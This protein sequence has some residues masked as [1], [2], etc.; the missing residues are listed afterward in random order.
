MVPFTGFTRG[1]TALKVNK[2]RAKW[3]G[4]SF[5]WIDMFVGI[6]GSCCR[7]FHLSIF[8]ALQHGCCYVVH[9]CEAKHFVNLH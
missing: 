3:R 8:Q 5:S 7:Q 1:L 2:N 6:L 4:Q 9:Q